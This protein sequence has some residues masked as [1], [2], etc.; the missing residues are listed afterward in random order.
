VKGLDTNILVRYLVEDNA[1]Q[2][3]KV[4]RLFETAMTGE[5]FFINTIV[6]C[7]LVWVLE[8]A[9][10]YPKSDILSVLEKIMTTSQFAVDEKTIVWQALKDYRAS[11]ADFSDCLIGQLNKTRGCSKTVSLDKALAKLE[12]FENL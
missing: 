8:S 1:A 3:D 9:Y 4:D 7:E 10:G 2:A 12:T 11:K 6:L 5:H